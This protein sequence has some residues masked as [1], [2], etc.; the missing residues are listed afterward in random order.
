MYI[1]PNTTV[2]LLKGVPLNSTY[3][4]TLTFDSPTEQYNYFNSKAPKTLN[5][6][7]YQRYDDG[8]ITVN[9][10]LSDVIDVNYMMFKNTSFENKWFY[11]F[12]DRVE[13]VSNTVTNVY[14][15]L[16]IMQ[17]WYFDWKFGQCYIEREH[18]TDDAMGQHL[19]EE[20]VDA[21]DFVLSHNGNFNTEN[22]YSLVMRT[23]SPIGRDDSNPINA[24]IIGAFGY[25]PDMFIR[26]GNTFE[27]CCYSFFPFTTQTDRENAFKSLTALFSD[28]IIDDFAENVTEMYIV[29][30]EFI[31]ETKTVTDDGYTYRLCAG[32]D[33]IHREMILNN[34]HE[35]QPHNR[36]LLTSQFCRLSVVGINGTQYDLDINTLRVHKNSDADTVVNCYIQGGVYGSAGF[37]LLP[38]TNTLASTRTMCVDTGPLDAISFKTSDIGNRMLN[39]SISGISTILK[40]FGIGSSIQNAENRERLRD[41]LRL[42][43]YGPRMRRRL[44]K[45]LD[46][47]FE[48]EHIFATRDTASVIDG[49]KTSGSSN[50]GAYTASNS[51]ILDN[52]FE[53]MYTFEYSV[54][55]PTLERIKYIDT[56]FNMFG[57]RVDRVGSVNINSRRRWNYVKTKWCNITNINCP[58]DVIVEIKNIMNNGIFF[59]HGESNVNNYFD[60]E[61]GTPIENEVVENG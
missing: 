29:P 19:L 18:V 42:P 26:L 53:N 24:N 7:M 37:R 5:A 34:Y 8:V 3:D 1:E 44:N 4:G 45:E 27:N 13:Y 25:R 41:E 10:T 22:G 60:D 11:A 48:R 28:G 52:L 14:Y 57:Y 17:T 2:K 40:V 43:K 54:Y 59:W 32:V 9:Y 49:L 38:Q 35:Y 58:N 31:G 15:T 61:Y 20:P 30:N 16:D 55:K 33:E 56:F 12:V 21:G 39:T 23:Y 36:K 6:Q 51:N 46:D 50:R 47:T